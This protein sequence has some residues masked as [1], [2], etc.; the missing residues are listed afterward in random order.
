MGLI[1]IGTAEQVKMEDR[2]Y[3][4]RSFRNY[5]YFKN[6]IRGFLHSTF[7]GTDLVAESDLQG[8]AM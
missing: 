4:W 2:F 3:I 5:N 8:K 6:S 1:Q 7:I